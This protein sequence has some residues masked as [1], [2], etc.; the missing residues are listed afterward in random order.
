VLPL[1]AG[2]CRVEFDFHYPQGIDPARPGRDLDF[3]DLVQREDVDICERVQRGM[4][5]GSWTT[6]RLNPL[7]ESGVHHFHELLRR[8]YR[9]DAVAHAADDA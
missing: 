8:A 9:D 4:A 7:R 1:G 6:G 5:S 2:R 3:S